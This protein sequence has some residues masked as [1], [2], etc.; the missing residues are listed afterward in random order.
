VA[1]DAL[2]R[3][4]HAEAA[5][6][7]LAAARGH[8]AAGHEMAAI[9]ACLLGIGANPGGVDLHLALA[10]LGSGGESADRAFEARRRLL[11][12]A[13]LD[14]DTGAI[15]RIHAAMAVAGPTGSQSAPLA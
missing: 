3:G 4:D 2:R 7:A 14:G 5:T 10:A 13:E 8:A 6:A 9:D 11:R 1:E 15:D 12:I